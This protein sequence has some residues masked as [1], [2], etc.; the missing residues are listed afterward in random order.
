LFE[1][2]G[3]LAPIVSEAGSTRVELAGLAPGVC[4]AEDIF[5]RL[6]GD[7]AVEWVVS[8]VCDHAGGKLLLRNDI[9]QA[10]CPMHGWRLDLET[11]R[12]CN[13]Q[14]AKRRLPFEVQDGVLVTE[15][16]AR[17]LQLPK[18]G[19]PVGPVEIRLLSHACALIDIAGVRIVTDPWLI[20]P[21]FTTG[22]WLAFPPRADAIDLLRSANLVFVSHNHPD[23]CHLE[24]LALLDRNMPII[25]PDFASKSAQK[26][27]ELGGHTNIVPLQLGH[28]YRLAGTEINLA[29]LKSGNF[30]DDSGIYLAAGDF[31]A[32]LTV[33]SAHLNSGVLPKN[34][35]L[36]MTSFAGGASGYPLCFDIYPLDVKRS[37]SERQRLSHRTMVIEYARATGPRAYMPYAGFFAEAALRD[38]FIA[39]NNRKNSVE[40][41][42]Q[43]VRTASP[44]TITIN[45]LETE[46]VTISR[47]TIEPKAIDLPRLYPVDAAYVESYLDR[48]RDAFPALSSAEIIDYFAASGFRDDL[49]LFVIPTDDE[50]RPSGDAVQVDFSVVPPRAQALAAQDAMQ[51]YDR[52]S[53][54]GKVRVK[55]LKVRT[56]SLSQV[57]SNRM[58]LEDLLIGFQCRVQRKPDVY[59]SDFW[60]HFSSIY[61]GP[62]HLRSSDRCDGCARIVHGINRVFETI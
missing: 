34:I 28:A 56:E 20:G 35:D 3:R 45:P 33:D 10:V 60:Y 47:S 30:R 24:T 39:D 49:C 38:G 17:S 43:A 48:H 29:I 7:G 22:W 23:H 26:I 41:A 59:N 53:S 6:N 14:M 5:F 9:G 62:E 18:S 4:T 54:E 2:L 27:L 32:L 31:E 16:N 57:I 1:P 52:W 13:V 50:F 40:E 44:G 8:R 51:R 42:L 12:Y 15:R 46:A 21:C 61:V 19:K 25:V 36:L 11:L 58:P 55:C 37:I